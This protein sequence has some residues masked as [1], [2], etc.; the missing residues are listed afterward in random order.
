MNQVDPDARTRMS[1]SKPD[2]FVGRSF[3]GF[4]IDEV[5]GRGGMG[6]VYKGTQL[7]LGRFV[8]IKVLT[9]DLAEDP[10]FLER[11]HREADVLSR[12]N[13]PNVVTV[14]DRGEVDGRPYLVMEYVEGTSV[15]EIM[16]EGPLEPHEALRIVSSVLAAL[17]H[18]HEKS[19]IHRD[20]K[21][22]NVL[23]ARGG[24]VKVADF[25]LSRLLGPEDG[26]RLTRTHL[27]LGTY[28][29]MAPEQREKAREADERSDVYATGVVLY[30]MLVGELPIGH[31]GLPSQQRPD[32]CDSRIDRIIERSLEKAP[33]DRYQRASEMAEAVSS[34]LDR[35]APPE[36]APAGPAAPT[37]Y[38]PVGFEY[39][40]DL[41]ATIDHV[42]G[43]VC[44]VLGFLT[45][46]GV[47]LHPRAILG[48]TIPFFV[49]FI[50]GIYLRSTAEKLRQYKLSA[51]TGQAVVAVLSAFTIVLLPFSIYSLWVLFGH[52]GRT[53]YEARSRGLDESDAARHTY[54]MLEEPY[55]GDA[56]PAPPPPPP[57]RPPTPSQIPVQSM[58]TSEVDERPRPAKMSGFV[59]AG[60]TLLLVSLFILAISQFIETGI[61][62]DYLAVPALVGV[63]FLVIGFFHALMTPGVRGALA[64]FF[65]LFLCGAAGGVLLMAAPAAVETRPV[66]FTLGRYERAPDDGNYERE[67]LESDARLEWIREVTGFEGQVRGKVHVIRSGPDRVRLVADREWYEVNQPQSQ[68]VV[69]AIQY[70]LESGY[71]SLKRYRLPVW[72]RE[73]E[74][75]LEGTPPPGVLP[76]R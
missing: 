33:D 65:G 61:E 64:A 59:K 69:Q 39:R 50:A 63:C 3:D 67:F 44:Y 35:A 12:L 8:A 29:Y 26:T 13:H 73:F 43:T 49:F 48:I 7:S 22:E 62:A 23:L 30:E 9:K 72:D 5:V 36:P 21:P 32:D 31:F 11:F 17:T 68:R 16:R 25:G 56:R 19:I 71:W 58:V 51:R 40:I 45:L 18:A 38:K 57:P 66:E 6:T 70:A 24:V 15:R 46:F 10:Q 20:I 41:V 1:E 37:S 75:R 53:Y 2:P 76:N 14:F 28:E 74:E 42:L 47:V 34:V 52:R 4:R 27:I 60:F 55:P 54:R